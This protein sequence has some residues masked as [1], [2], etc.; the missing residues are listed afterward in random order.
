M[1]CR[2]CEFAGCEV[3][4]LP[5]EPLII[6]TVGKHPM[7]DGLAVIQHEIYVCSNC[8][9]YFLLVNHVAPLARPSQNAMNAR[10]MKDNEVIASEAS[11]AKV[12]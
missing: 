5:Q 6:H 9:N 10:A 1:Q 3:I 7:E 4:H 8:K 2:D 12:S 11:G